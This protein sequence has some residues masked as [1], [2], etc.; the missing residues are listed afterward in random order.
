MAADSVPNG[1]PAPSLPNGNPGPGGH[2][3]H[4]PTSAPRADS[5]P[6]AV[7][8][9]ACRFGGDATSPS[10]L[11]ELCTAGK[12][13]WSP[14][15]AQRFDVQSWYHPDNE[16]SGKVSHPMPDRP[17]SLFFKPT[18][19]VRGRV[20]SSSHAPFFTAVLTVWDSR[21]TLWA[22]IS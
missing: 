14:I 8:G 3:P 22:V 4:K 11:W 19:S 6:I 1:I 10:K 5:A 12:D 9:M 16:K 7:V 20:F 15:P 21:A 13:S 2:H 18:P 17:A